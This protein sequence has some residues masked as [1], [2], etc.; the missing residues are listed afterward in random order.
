MS[1]QAQHCG[2]DSRFCE[3]CKRPDEIKAW[4]RELHRV[5]I[6]FSDAAV[7]TGKPAAVAALIELL[8]AMAT[9]LAVRATQDP[10]RA[11]GMIR[12]ITT[13]RIHEIVSRNPGLPVMPVPPPGSKSLIH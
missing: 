10:I 9:D 11:I 7:A 12:E 8:A 5:V 3:A 1:D 2:V 6:T 4:C 13:D